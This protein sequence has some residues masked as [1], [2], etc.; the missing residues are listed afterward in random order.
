MQFMSWKKYLILKLQ[1]F[2]TKWSFILNGYPVSFGAFGSFFP[3][4]EKGQH[5]DRW[6]PNWNWI[7]WSGLLRPGS[8]HVSYQP[9]CTT[10]SAFLIKAPVRIPKN[11]IKQPTVMPI[12]FYIWPQGVKKTFINKPRSRAGHSYQVLGK[13]PLSLGS[14]IHDSFIQA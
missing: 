14:Y 13:E 5:R 3:I 9:R 8:I 1:K 11:T 2:W 10:S 7:M 6:Q 4:V 12:Y